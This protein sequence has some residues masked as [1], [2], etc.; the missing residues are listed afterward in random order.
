MRYQL[1][2]ARWLLFTEAPIAP[3]TKETF[4]ALKA[5]HP[6]AARSVPPPAAP[7]S[8]APHFSDKLVREA[9]ATFSPTSAAGLFGY[10]PRLL[11]QCARAVNLF[12]SG[13]APPFL[14]PFIA[15]GVSIALAKPNRGV[16]PL[17]CGDA[18]RRLV[19][20]CFCHGGKK[21]ISA[22]F[23]GQNYGVGCPG[24]VEIVGH[25]LRDSLLRHKDSDMALLKIDFKNAFNLLD[26]DVFVEACSA[27]FPGLE[28]WTR[29]CYSQPPL[30]I[31]DHNRIFVSE[32]GVQQGDPLGPLYF[33]CGLQRLVDRITELNPDYQKW[34]MDDGGIIG[35]KELLLRV[36]DILKS[37]GPAIG[38]ILNPS[39]C[40]WSWLNP[41]CKDPCPIE[42]VELV[43]T[44]KIQILGV[45]LGSDDC[46]ASHVEK[47][48]IPAALRVTEKLMEFEDS[49]AAMYLLRISFGIIRANHFMRT[50]PI[51]QWSAQAVEFDHIM[52]NASERIVGQPFTEDAYDQACVSPRVGG[53]GIRRA[54]EHAPI[55][56][57]ASFFASAGQ[58]GESWIQPACIPEPAVASQQRGSNDLDASIL[59]RLKRKADARN[60]QRLQ[61]LDRK[62]ANSWVTALPSA[63]DGR[64]AVLP[65]RIFQTA[66]YR[67]LGLP[68]FKKS[69]PCPLCEQI[70]DELGDHALCCRKTSDLV[71]RHN[72]LRG[73]LFRLADVGRLN[74]E[75]EKLGILG[76]TDESK[77]RP[78]DV[79][80]PLWGNNKGL[81][82]DVA[83]ICPVAPSH[84][85]E[86][87]PCE[88]YAALQKHARYDAGFV[89][90]RYDFAAM[91]FETSG[92]VN[93]EGQNILKQLIRFA[94]KRENAGNSS[95]AGR[96]WARV[97]CCI[98]YS[99]AQSI[100]NRD[101]S[102]AGDC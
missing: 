47:E 5:L 87:D 99:V 71:T 84:V 18:I 14:Q 75:L 16:R 45:P 21:E 58:C 35:S 96:A 59:D 68:V 65:P 39:K 38:L 80:I 12:A 77:R 34:Y 9:L 2:Y 26:R 3:K 67:L 10:R 64:D 37:E 55:A 89:G 7:M 66:V 32:R 43:P 90:S 4:T 79:S 30:L 78:G 20:K 52:R 46:V 28:R 29:W 76:P 94:S 57:S 74:P 24:G 86:E 95:Y 102:A 98:Q 22:S 33:C 70:M 82:I 83:V 19:A 15:G 17:C 54:V 13:N 48:L 91:V 51:T 50:T 44:S 62:H 61:R 73:W 1:S 49:Q 100:L 92:A 63:T 72:R 6:E 60:R 42:L 81:A 23:K 85:A 56:F 25:S 69:L 40:E 31:Y 27:R 101:V 97:S 53:L 88:H 36:W 93:K 8:V 11:Q 41:A